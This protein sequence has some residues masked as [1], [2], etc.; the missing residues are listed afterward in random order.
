MS[1][2][3]GNNIGDNCVGLHIGGIKEFTNLCFSIQ[4]LKRLGNAVYLSVNARVTFVR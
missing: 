4:L 2:S 1:A 3:S